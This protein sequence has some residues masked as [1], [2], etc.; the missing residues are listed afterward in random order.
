MPL[1][2]GLAGFTTTTIP[3]EGLNIVMMIALMQRAVEKSTGA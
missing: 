2:L 1:G 3:T